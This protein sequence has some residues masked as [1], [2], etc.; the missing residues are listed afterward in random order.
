V[1]FARAN[2]WSVVIETLPDWYAFYT[3]YVKSNEAAVGGPREDLA[4]RLIHASPFQTLEGRA[5]L[6]GFLTHSLNVVS[7]TLRPHNTLA[8]PLHSQLNI[9]NSRLAKLPIVT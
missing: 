1:D 8:L 9:R 2:N 5:K 6:F 7:L 3:K 4:S